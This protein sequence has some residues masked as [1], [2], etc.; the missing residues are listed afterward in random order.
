MLLHNEPMNAEAILEYGRQVIAQEARA[1]GQLALDAAFVEA[2][3][4][5]VDCRGRVVVTGIGKAG[6]IG[7]KISATMASTGT[8]SIELHPV[9]ALHGD[10]GRVDE[11]DVVLALSNSGETEELL[12]LLPAVRQT[13]AALIALTGDGSSTLARHSDVV[14]DIGKIDEAC[15]LGMAPSTSTTAML[16]LGDALSLTVAH[17]KDFKPEDFAKFHPGGKL[18]LL[19]MKVSEVMRTGEAVPVLPPETTVRDLLMAV[20]RAR[21]GSGIIVDTVGRLEGIFSDGDLR[22]C[23]SVDG[24]DDLDRPVGDLMTRDPTRI[25]GDELVTAAMHLMSSRRHN[26]LPVVDADGHVIGLIDAQD[27]LALGLS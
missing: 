11:H 14:L 21:S 5:V 4:C 23:L 8:P 16:A 26:Q 15:P 10:L 19:L 6:L 24:P 3:R 2:V 13:G 27:V 7:A 17:L 18:G 9:E 22:R 12:R 1:L 25:R 20:T